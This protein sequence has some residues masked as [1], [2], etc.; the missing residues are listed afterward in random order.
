MIIQG[1]W[2]FEYLLKYFF[3]IPTWNPIPTPG[4]ADEF[5]FSHWEIHYLANL[6][7]LGMACF[8]GAAATPSYHREI[9]IIQIP[10]VE[11]IHCFCSTI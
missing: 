1:I 5:A 4:F 7:I 6:Y 11:D 3:H 2:R 8:V 9:P 10:L